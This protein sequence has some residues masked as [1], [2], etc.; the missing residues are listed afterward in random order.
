MFETSDG[1]ELY[2]RTGSKETHQADFGLKLSK[3]K[4]NGVYEFKNKLCSF[5]KSQPR[6][7][8]LSILKIWQI[9][10]LICS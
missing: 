2:K 6:V 1:V 10:A 4:T 3:R 9:S 5:L 8:S 7:Y